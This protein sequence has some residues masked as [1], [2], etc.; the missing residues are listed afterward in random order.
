VNITL[1][2]DIDKKELPQVILLR[3]QDIQELSVLPGQLAR[4]IFHI[5]RAAAGCDV[6]SF[7]HRY[8]LCT[9]LMA[10]LKVVDILD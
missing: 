7:Q 5:D 9:F 3:D 1:V 6:S 8:V 2:G 4:K 10:S